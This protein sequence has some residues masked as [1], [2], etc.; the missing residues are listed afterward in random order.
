MRIPSV[1]VSGDGALLHSRMWIN[2]TLQLATSGLNSLQSNCQT[3]LRSSGCFLCFDPGK[4]IFKMFVFCWS[5]SRTVMLSGFIPAAC[6]VVT[7]ENDFVLR[8]TGGKSYF[9]PVTCLFP[10]SRFLLSHDMRAAPTERQRREPRWAEPW[11]EL[12]GGERRRV[13]MIERVM[14]FWTVTDKRRQRCMRRLLK[15]CKPHSQKIKL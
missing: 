13:E 7:L 2:L 3:L 4:R 1:I 11:W 15:V 14:W 10:L 8:R 5:D 9:L 12:K 6:P